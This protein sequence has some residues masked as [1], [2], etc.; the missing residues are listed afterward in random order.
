MVLSERGAPILAL[1]VL[2]NAFNGVIAMPYSLQL[3]AAWASLPLQINIAALFIFTPATY[4]LAMRYGAIGG[5]LTWCALNFG[6]IL[7]TP[8][9]MHRRLLKDQ[10]IAWYLK[11][12][13]P[14]AVV[15][16]A[17]TLVM[18]SLWHGQGSRLAAGFHVFAWVAATLQLPPCLSCAGS[19]HRCFNRHPSRTMQ[20]TDRLH[21]WT[22]AARS[23]RG[24]FLALAFLLCG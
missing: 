8:Q 16:I 24:S 19:C 2:G 18:W 10:K 20:T 3:A 7:L 23:A 11:D 4:V 15:S 1:L 13:A 14:V 6:Y 17:V 21:S 9:L 22:T 5:A 12:L